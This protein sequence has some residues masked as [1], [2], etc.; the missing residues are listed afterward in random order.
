MGLFVKSKILRIKD[1]KIGI[2]PSRATYRDID[3]ERERE[4]DVGKLLTY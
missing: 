1:N 3:K 2:R 4:M